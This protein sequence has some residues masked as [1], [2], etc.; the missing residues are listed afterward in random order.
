MRS[1]DEY[2]R[3][4]SLIAAGLTDAEI[5]RL[6]AIPRGT[7]QSWRH[8]KGIRHA[9]GGN[10]RSGMRC[11]GGCDAIASRV[12]PSPQAY[13]HLLGLYLGDGTISEMK[14]GVMRLRIFLD[15][16]Y[17]RI[18]AGCVESMQVIR[19]TGAVSVASQT[20]CVEVSARWR[21]WH[22]VFPQHGPGMKHTRDLTLTPW[23]REIVE[24]EPKSLLRGLFE[25]DGS[26][27]INPITRRHAGR[28]R[29]YHY[30][31]YM[32]ANASEDLQQ[33]FKD[34]CD[35]LGVHWTQ[36]NRKNVAV[37]RREY[38]AFLDEFLG[39]KT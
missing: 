32:F 4:M 6:T 39:P 15:Q 33:L 10:R 19:G 16:K 38:V 14:R 9:S 23:Q 30:S 25:S 7:V 18:I 21:H 37:S 13:A 31:R 28:T 20:G 11:D 34:T 26:R 12:E 1:R 29:Q 17:P 3:V 2:E 22:C 36:A 8:P 24:T 5:G 35:L 27:H